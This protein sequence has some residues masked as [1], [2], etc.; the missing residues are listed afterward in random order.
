M[1][2]LPNGKAW[3]MLNSSTVIARQR[4]PPVVIT[5]SGFLEASHQ[6]VCPMVLQAMTREEWV[7]QAKA[8]HKSTAYLLDMYFR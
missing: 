5:I 1:C 7:S 3:Q 6:C 8:T 4:R 2:H